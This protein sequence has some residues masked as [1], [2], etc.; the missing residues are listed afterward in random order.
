MSDRQN[1]RED[2]EGG[3]TATRTT[4]P[5][6]EDLLPFSQPDISQAEIDEVVA[7]LRSGWITTGPRTKEFE[8][9]FAAYVGA[10]HAIAVNSCTGGL[11]VALAAA[12][13]G[14][15]DEVV[16]PTMTFCATANVVTHL[17]A[18][19]ILVDVEPDTLNLDP[20]C[21]AAAITS[22][23]RA[24]IPVHLYGHPCEMDR[25]GDIARAHDMRVVEDAA[26]AVGAQWRGQRIGSIS[27]ATVFSF[28][29]TKNL[30]TAEG[31]MITTDDD[32]YAEKLRL[33]SLHG[34][35]RDAW[36]RYAQG[37]WYYEV[38]VPGFKYN[39]TD[40]QAA[41][42]LHQL[43]RLEDMTQRRAEL[44]AQYCAGLGNL[45]EI[46]LP[47]VRPDIRHAW[48]LFPIRLR[49]ELLAIS[50]AQFID[51]LKAEGIGTS[52]HFIPLHRHP[53]YR[54]RFD[55]QPSDLPVAD[56]AYERL[57]SLPLYPGMTEGD[58]DN[59]IEALCRIVQRN[60]R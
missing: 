51:Q 4:P 5:V 23:T 3:Q 41:L 24:V 30:T 28:Y 19:P 45:R 17:G 16:V 1:H 39:L 37:S 40:L 34:M 15:G 38:S 8:Q 26:H 55:L 52:V 7:T 46:E 59:V 33:W 60:R 13:I 29:A 42:G 12:G 2:E 11:H 53:Y 56:A 48:H 50:R 32:E 35:S 6:R 36:K 54:D 9:R 27:S 20:T 49:T 10:R 14:V 25:I 31:G 47:T 18:T 22:H 57:I 21:F 58:V 44:A 43:S